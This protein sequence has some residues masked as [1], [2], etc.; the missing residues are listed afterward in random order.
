LK[1]F[2]AVVPLVVWVGIT[3]APADAAEGAE[4][5]TALVVGTSGDYAP[6]SLEG[7]DAGGEYRGFDVDLARRY[8]ADRGLEVRFVRFRWPALL[9]D[10]EAGRFDVAMSG[11][12]VRPER[13][14]GGRFGVP[15]LETGALALVPEESWSELDALD[16]PHIR[17]GVNAGGHLER[18]AAQRFPR[19]THVAIGDNTSVLEALRQ[20]AVQAVVTDSAEA[21]SWIEQMP[22]LVPLGPFTLDR[23]APLVRAEKRELA[24]DLDRWLLERER[25]GSLE[26][27]RVQHLGPGPWRATAEPLAALL[28]SVDERLS[29]MPAVGFVKRNTGVP[30]EVLE[31]EEI[32]LDAASEA[33]L[34]AASEREVVAPS[35]ISIRRFFRAQ[36]DAAKQVQLDTVADR[37]FELPEPN[38]DLDEDLRPA[39][40][41]IGERIARLVLELPAGTDAARVRTEADALLREPRLSRSSRRMLVDAI[42]GLVPAAP[43]RGPDQTRD[44]ARASSPAATGSTRQTP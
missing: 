27:L 4:L 16:R 41:R 37:D 31:R 18:A 2:L 44:R 9:T 25:D 5:T 32:V 36:L 10:L 8:A 13:S 17:I 3:P 11:V 28:A 22:G 6:F 29:L 7:G 23:K 21:P 39:L 20:G 43:R 26:E 38:P 30:I 19:A 42:V 34:E 15:V 24:V 35:V 33:V 12:T 14:A 1:I 40:L